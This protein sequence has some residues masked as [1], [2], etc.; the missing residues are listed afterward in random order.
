MLRRRNSR[1]A[2]Q[3]VKSLTPNIENITGVIV[4]VAPQLAKLNQLQKVQVSL[5]KVLS[6]IDLF[7]KQ[8]SPVVH[9]LDHSLDAHALVSDFHREVSDLEDHMKTLMVI[10]NQLQKWNVHFQSS[11]DSFR[12]LA[13]DTLMELTEEDDGF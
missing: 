9:N 11:F 12:G 5:N 2:S 1:R 13:M 10:L 7:D 6:Q 3:N 8:V 4:K